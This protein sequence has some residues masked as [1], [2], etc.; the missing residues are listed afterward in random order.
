MYKLALLNGFT[1]FLNIFVLHVLIWRIK[2]PSA[3]IVSLF[4]LFLLFPAIIF[5][6]LLISFFSEKELI[7]SSF[8]LYFA[9]ACAYIQTYPAAQANAPSLEIVYFLFKAGGEGLSE[10]EIIEKFDN[11]ILVFNRMDDLF[12]ENFV[13]QK[14][15]K[16]FLTKKGAVFINIFRFYRK[17]LGLKA[18]QG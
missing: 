8:L 17:I 5:L 14:E 6:I 12:K 4:G 18:G 2:K 11:Q 7:L 15:N 16:I 1:A 9:L 3:Q 13:F 10:K